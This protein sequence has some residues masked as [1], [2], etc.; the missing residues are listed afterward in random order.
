MQ[1]LLRPIVID[2]I[3]YYCKYRYGVKVEQA[4]LGIRVDFQKYRKY[5]KNSRD[6]CSITNTFTFSAFLMPFLRFNHYHPWLET[7]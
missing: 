1:I 3:L 6:I 2:H 4:S 7:S 5:P